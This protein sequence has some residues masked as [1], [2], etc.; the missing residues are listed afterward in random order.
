MVNKSFEKRKFHAANGK[1]QACT[2]GAL[3]FFLLCFGGGRSFPMCSHY[4]PLKFLKW[5]PTMFPNFATFFP[6]SASIV[7]LFYPNICLR[8]MVSSF[9]L[10]R[11]A[12]GEEPY[13]SKWSLFLLFWG[14]FI[15]SFF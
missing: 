15:V 6:T 7:P 1:A 5:V 13:T 12:K 8:K 4:V 14:V 3:I 10:Y 11:W 9:H 2:Q